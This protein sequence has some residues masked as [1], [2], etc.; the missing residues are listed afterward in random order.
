MFLKLVEVFNE[1]NW[2]HSSCW[3]ISNW[4]EAWCLYSWKL[5]WWKLP[6]TGAGL[7]YERVSPGNV[8]CT[9]PLGRLV[10]VRCNFMLRLGTEISLINSVLPFGHTELCDLEDGITGINITWVPTLEMLGSYS[11]L[12]FKQC[13]ALGCIIPIFQLPPSFWLLSLNEYWN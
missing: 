4:L 5:F 3:K 7:R 13:Q 8:S 11:C 10:C 6:E 9:Q 2:E 12:P 1:K